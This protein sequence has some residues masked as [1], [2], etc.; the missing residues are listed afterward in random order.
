MEVATMSHITT[1]VTASA[2]ELTREMTPYLGDVGEKITKAITKNISDGAIQEAK[3]VQQPF[4][5]SPQFVPKMDL[6]GPSASNLNTN[7]SQINR[8]ISGQS[9]LPQL[10]EQQIKEK[11]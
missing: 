5:N 2:E 4:A 6:G 8:L 3:A 11:K 10:T 1:S 9:G 7:P